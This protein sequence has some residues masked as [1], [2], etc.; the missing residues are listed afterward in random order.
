MTT[1]H[2]Q[3]ARFWVANALERDG[4][5]RTLKAQEYPDDVRNVRAANAL[6]AA[7]KYVRTAPTSKGLERLQSLVELCT[8]S[9]LD[10]TGS[11]Y[12]VGFPGPESQRVATRYFFDHAPEPADSHS[13][14]E[15]LHDLYTACLRDLSE[16]MHDVPAGSPLEQLLA[17]ANPR[18]TDPVVALLT[19]IRDLLRERLPHAAAAQET[20]DELPP[21]L[22]GHGATSRESA[23]NRTAVQHRS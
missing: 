14:E 3:A 2:G 19:E 8:E 7:A 17:K 10:L 1:P 9:G 16:P 23:R 21:A 15:L 4:E 20:A 12:E 22:L 5:W 18:P 11:A 6:H 13:H